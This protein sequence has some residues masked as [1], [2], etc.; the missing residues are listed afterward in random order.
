M[1]A[2]GGIERVLVDKMNYLL[3]VGH[4]VYLLTANQGNHPLSFSLDE[5]VHHKDM[6][7]LT[8][9]QYRYRGLR[10]LWERIRRNRILYR[11]LSEEIRQIRP[12]V[13]VTTT[14]SYVSALGVLKGR[15]PLV[16]E[17]HSSYDHVREYDDNSP[18]HHYDT[19]RA[20][21]WLHLADIIVALT[22]RDARRWR[23][24]YRRV[25][26]IPNIV[27]LN[28]TGSLS[29][30]SNKRAIFVGRNCRQKAIPDLL[31]AWALVHVRHPDWQLDMYVER[32]KS[33]LVRQAES[34]HAN[35]RVLS[36]VRHIMECY[37]ESSIFVQTSLYEPF[38]LAMAEAMSCGLPVVA[39]EGDGPCSII[40]DGADGFV[41]GGRSIEAFADRVS[42][43]IE[44][45]TLRLR[46]GHSAA[47]SVLRY[48]PDM[49]MPAWLE[50]F[51]SLCSQR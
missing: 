14:N 39:F 41:V 20:Y 12:D 28:A 43:L 46:I 8:H 34:L 32:E 22:D 26:S 42:Q 23:Q 29:T 48:A 16:V 40:T 5:R 30:C 10:R 13:I 18:F 3:T 38:G 9:M 19:R 15:I 44:S 45:E 4:D 1:I 7:V 50:L 51:E 24:H 36:P 6:R 2:F 25:V 17:S 35:I 49:V 27:H 37:L 31:Q 33:E 47:R 11:C 21:R